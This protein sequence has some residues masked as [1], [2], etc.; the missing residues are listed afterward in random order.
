MRA[1]TSICNLTVGDF[2]PRQFP[3]PERLRTGITQALEAGETNYPPSDGVQELRQS[4]QRY[5]R[6]ELGLDYPL[7][8]VLIA[9]GARPLIYATYRA[10]VDEGDRVMYPLPSWNNTHYVHMVGA[11]GVPIPCTSEDR[12]L[13]T[14]EALAPELPTARL[15]VP[16]LAAQSDGHGDRARSAARHLRRDRRREPASRGDR[17]AAALPHVRPHLLAALRRRDEARH[18]ARARAG[19]GALHDLRG[20]HLQ[21]VRG[22]G[23]ARG[24]V[25]RARRRHRAH[26]RDPRT[27]RRVGAARRTVRDRRT[28]RRCIR[29]RGV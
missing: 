29:P 22:H 20:R 24:V 19:D 25:R 26:E 14:L 12:F 3:I 6:R 21:G 16:Q 7:E 10:V 5:Y 11:K 17:R 1:G 18:A 28:A 8:S 2:D 15:A 27:R 4:V 9:G 13:P 23:R